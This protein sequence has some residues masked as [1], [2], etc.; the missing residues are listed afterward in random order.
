MVAGYSNQHVTHIPPP[1]DLVP[2]HQSNFTVILDVS[3]SGLLQI[4]HLTAEYILTF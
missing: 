1:I 2:E 3:H 4:N